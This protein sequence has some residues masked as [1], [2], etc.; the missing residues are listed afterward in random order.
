ME[1]IFIRHG[2]GKHTLNLPT[3]LKLQ[4]PSLTETG[5]A[6]AMSLQ[7]QFPLTESDIIVV[8]PSKRTLQ[9]T[10]IWSEHVNC[11][12]VV[13][14]LISP[15]MFPQKPGS[16]TLPCDQLLSR[17]AIMDCFPT[18]SIT[19]GFSED[20]WESGI[21]TMPER[22]FHILAQGFLEWCGQQ[23]VERIYIVSHDGTITSYR[24]V[25]RNENLTRH[26]FLTDA[27][28]IK[29]YL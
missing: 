27:G 18:F 26:D 8:S 13:N 6:Q 14:P 25:I 10:S 22:E 7:Q 2:Q 24:E 11:H 23:S 3:S 1:L 5:I 4:N 19:E 15:R 21:N 12:K 28:W 17:E 9:T 20:L 16:S 29:E